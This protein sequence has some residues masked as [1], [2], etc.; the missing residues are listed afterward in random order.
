MGP[1]DIL[2]RQH[3]ELEEQL[4]ALEADDGARG[5]RAQALITLLRLHARLEERCV[6]PLL[7]RVEG[8]ARADAQAEDHLAMGELVDELVELTP[9]EDA[10][11][12]RFTALEDLLVA[13]TRE[14]EAETFPR[15]ATALTEEE[16]ERLRRALADMDEE[17]SASAPRRS[18]PKRL[19]ET[20]R[21]GD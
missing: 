20:S 10:W 6:H 7:A 15:L 13:H 14:E 9:G 5:E 18:G 19:L 1:F 12:A 21:W 11:W 3:R 16:Q 2:T 4:A 8:R 17:L